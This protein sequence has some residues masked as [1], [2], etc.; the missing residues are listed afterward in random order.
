MDILKYAHLV[1]GKDINIFVLR[2]KRSLVVVIN[3][4]NFAQKNVKV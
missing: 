4:K 1:I 2:A 3:I